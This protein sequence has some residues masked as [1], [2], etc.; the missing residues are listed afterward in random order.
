MHDTFALT[1]SAV[2]VVP[3]TDAGKAS[4]ISD[5]VLESLLDRSW[6]DEE[7]DSKKAA[8]AAAGAAT[9]K[10]KAVFAVFEAS[11]DA[12]GGGGNLAKLFGED[13]Q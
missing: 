7:G 2:E 13:V 3:S 8:I 1:E 12:D 5:E 10:S 9:G 6:G 4:V 11:G